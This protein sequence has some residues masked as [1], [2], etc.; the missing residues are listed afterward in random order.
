MVGLGAT[1]GGVGT[2]LLGAGVAGAGGG[3]VV[4]GGIPGDVGI[5]GPGG[6]G[7]GM[8][9]GGPVVSVGAVVSVGDVGDVGFVNWQYQRAITKA[10]G[11]ETAQSM[12]IFFDQNMNAWRFTF[13][14]DAKPVLT[15]A[16]TPPNSS[17]T[18]SPFVFLADRA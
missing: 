6:G 13:R 4:G 1:V 14:V 3:A 16:V 2:G 5:P 9:S 12:H 10:G 7:I 17:A 15:A 11:I 8:P 18:R